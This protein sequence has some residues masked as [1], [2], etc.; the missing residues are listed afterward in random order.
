LSSGRRQC[1]VEN[2]HSEGRIASLV[3][4]FSRSPP[5]CTTSSGSSPS[6]TATAAPPSWPTATPASPPRSTK[7][8]RI[9]GRWQN[10][11]A[12]SRIVTR[13]SQSKPV[14]WRSRVRWWCFR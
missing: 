7:P 3:R 9:A 11:D 12:E 2:G 6:T 13:N 4:I 14:W 1:R 10:P 5:S 8:R